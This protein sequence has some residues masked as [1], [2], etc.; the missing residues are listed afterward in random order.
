[1]A[2]LNPAVARVLK[3]LHYPLSS[4]F[5]DPVRTT[6][7]RPCRFRRCFARR[8]VFRT[9]RLIGLT[10]FPEADQHGCERLAEALPYLETA[11]RINPSFLPS[12]G[13]LLT[14]D[15]P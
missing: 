6:P 4:G 13:S 5:F 11:V 9:A 2:T 10:P 12:R 7:A 15:L 1:M 3:R 14:G 8:D